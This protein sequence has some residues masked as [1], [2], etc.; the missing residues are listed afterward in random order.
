MKKIFFLKNLKYKL[1]L[2]FLAIAL[3]PFFV[4]EWLNYQKAKKGFQKEAFAKLS[5]IAELKTN[6]IENYL[7]EKRADIQVLAQTDNV[8]SAFKKLKAYYNSSGASATGPYDVTSREYLKIFNEIDPFFNTYVNAFEYDDIFLM[9]RNTGMSCI[10]PKI[11]G[12]AI[13]ILNPS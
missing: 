10:K 12:Q 11:S 1:L 9:A 5:S 13:T 2:I 3:I 8:I 4:M 7:V 6:Q